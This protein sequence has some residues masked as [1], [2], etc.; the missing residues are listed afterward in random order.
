VARNARRRR[1]DVPR[2]RV[3]K[4]EVVGDLAV[5]APTSMEKLA[6]PALAAERI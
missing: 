6:G 2:G 5:Q 4:D 3:L 1:G